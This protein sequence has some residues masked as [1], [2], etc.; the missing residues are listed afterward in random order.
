MGMLLWAP[1]IHR[2][3]FT[4]SDRTGVTVGGVDSSTASTQCGATDAMTACRLLVILA[5]LQVSQFAAFI[6]GCAC[7]RV[8]SRGPVLV[9]FIKNL[10]G[11]A[12]HS[13]A[14]K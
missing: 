6:G 2:Q 8:S 1:H 13:L 9:I 7:A 4:E 12:S 3:A 11:T 10:K 5:W 14:E